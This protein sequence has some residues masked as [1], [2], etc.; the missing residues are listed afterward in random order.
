MYVAVEEIGYR[1]V[2]PTDP[3]KA[4]ARIWGMKTTLKRA[5]VDD[6]AT[7]DRAIVEG[8]ETLDLR[9][10]GFMF[11]AKD[12]KTLLRGFAERDSRLTNS[13][14]TAVFCGNYMG[15]AQR[16]RNLHEFGWAVKVTKT[17]N[18][19][20]PGSTATISETQQLLKRESTFEGGFFVFIASADKVRATDASLRIIVAS[21]LTS[22][23]AFI[24]LT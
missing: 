4:Q 20:N 18:A 10:Y 7:H 15:N 6:K 13:A 11:W 16:Y 1:D 22:V 17:R 8:L 19:Q 21:S 3:A 2:L 5:W 24:R 9:R 14:Q 12:K 23:G